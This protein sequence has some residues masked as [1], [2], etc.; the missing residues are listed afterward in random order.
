MTT[1]LHAAVVAAQFPIYQQQ[2]LLRDQRAARMARFK[3]MACYIATFLLGA[4]I[5]A[6]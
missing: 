3:R 5:A 1:G 2:L 6:L 4:W